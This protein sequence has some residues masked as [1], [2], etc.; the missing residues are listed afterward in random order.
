MVDFILSLYGFKEI[1]LKK[2]LTLL[3]EKLIIYL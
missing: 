3:P 1:K 2:L